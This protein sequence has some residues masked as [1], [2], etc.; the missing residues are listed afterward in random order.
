MFDI[1]YEKILYI[2]ILNSFSGSWSDFLAKPTVDILL[3]RL[4]TVA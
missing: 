2:M 3:I 4:N 1:D